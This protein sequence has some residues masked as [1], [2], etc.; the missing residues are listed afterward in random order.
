[1]CPD[2]LVSAPALKLSNLL[3]VVM[4]EDGRC[5]LQTQIRPTRTPYFSF[6]E[7]VTLYHSPSPFPWSQ[8]IGS[9]VDKTRNLELTLKD[10]NLACAGHLHKDVNITLQSAIFYL[11]HEPRSKYNYI[12]LDVQR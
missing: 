8:L 11:T 9:E 1:M 7:M 3:V 5:L 12:I 10:S 6:T 4:A 2:L